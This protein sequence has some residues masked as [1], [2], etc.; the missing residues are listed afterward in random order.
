ML[1]AYFHDF[2]PF[3]ATMGRALCHLEAPFRV[4]LGW[5]SIG[6]GTTKHIQPVVHVHSKACMPSRVNMHPRS[7][8]IMCGSEF[9][10]GHKIN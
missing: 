4:R 5:S 2:L 7:G 1:E 6:P 10:F 8:P 3:G 9:Y